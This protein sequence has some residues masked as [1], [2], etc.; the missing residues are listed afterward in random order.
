M[1]HALDS[2]WHD[3]G[4]QTND[5]NQLDDDGRAFL[6]AALSEVETAAGHETPATGRLAE[7]LDAAVAAR[8]SDLH[9]SAGLAPHLRIS[10]VLRPM[11][12]AKALAPAELRDLLHAALT[13]EQRS[14]LTASGDLDAGLTLGSEGG[15]PR[16]FR[17]S[18]FRQSGTLAAAIRIVPTEIPPLDALG[19]PPVITRF[20]ELRSGLV[21]V[22]GSTGSG[23]STTLAAMI[24][25]VNRSRADHIVTVEDPIEYRYT[26]VLSVVTQR[27]VGADT[28]SFA[29]AL[30]HALRQDPDVILIG[31]LR[32]LETIRIA[33]TAAETGHLVF[34]TLHSSDTTSAINRVVD[35]FPSDQQAQIRSQ[36]ALS[37]EGCISQRLLPGLNGALVPATEVMVATSA[38]RNLIR[39][40]KVHQLRSVLETGGD[41]GMHT[42]DQSLATLVLGRRVDLTVARGA[43]QSVSNLESLVTR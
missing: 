25:H 14:V 38:V 15:V 37:I 18:L 36:L 31:E 5:W 23:K 10:G 11:A 43:A 2:V 17:A 21:L 24:E 39:E 22:T 8:A 3:P 40:D 29:T 7:L 9:L 13:P 19:L 30:R 28:Q 33:L 35:V 1:D 4:A 26:P 20:V 34:A 27:E 32:D 41:V 42:F 6:S 12:G 16:R